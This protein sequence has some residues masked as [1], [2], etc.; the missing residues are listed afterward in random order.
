MANPRRI[1]SAAAAE[2]AA[3]AE[4]AVEG[5]ASAA[6]KG[7]QAWLGSQAELWRELDV[8]GRGFMQRRREAIA[9]A[10]RSL[11][12]M[13]NCRDVV[14][15]LK[16]QQHSLAEAVQLL[17]A[18]M[19]ELS[20]LALTLSQRAMGGVLKSGRTMAEDTR[21]GEDFTLSAAGAKPGRRK[22]R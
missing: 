2:H 22:R 4:R 17:A 16:I 14:E 11:E 3:R 15:A 8:A 12:E 20:V 19:G 7:A 13:Q 9:S 10:Q 18:E 5:A 21:N 1:T 6:A